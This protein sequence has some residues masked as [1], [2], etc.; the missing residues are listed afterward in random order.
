MGSKK[1]QL[2]FEDLI[3]KELQSRSFEIIKNEFGEKTYRRKVEE[4]SEIIPFIYAHYGRVLWIKPLIR[5]NF[6]RIRD[7]YQQNTSYKSRPHVCIGNHLLEIERYVKNGETTKRVF[8]NHSWE[9]EK[10]E[11]VV[12][13]VDRLKEYFQSVIKPYFDENNTI[14]RV[15]ELLNKEPFVPSI[16]NN[17][18]PLRACVGL[19]AAKL[20]NN[21]GFEELLSSYDE[22][23]KTGEAS[24]QEDYQKIRTYL[25]SES[26]D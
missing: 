18:I 19:I 6:D 24:F 22:V 15:D 17:L 25:T 7:I 2:L 4:I 9:V 14:A 8:A 10:E 20:N 21:P 11:E 23:I 16:H 13:L 3:E 12:E 1:L 5:L 26:P